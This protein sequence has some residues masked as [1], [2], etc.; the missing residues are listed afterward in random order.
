MLPILSVLIPKKPQAMRKR[1]KGQSMRGKESIDT[2]V[3]D[4]LAGRI[5]V[6]AFALWWSIAAVNAQQSSTASSSGSVLASSG[7]PAQ[8]SSS[9]GLYRGS[10]IKGLLSS[11]GRIFFDNEQNALM[12]MD[13]PENIE[14]ID[15]Y[16]KTVDVPSK[17]VL[18]E[19]RVVEVTLEG[20]HAF[21]VNWTLFAKKQGW[22]LGQF[23]LFS[24]LAGNGIKQSIPYKTTYYPPNQTTIGAEDPFSLTIF[25]EN[26]NVVLKALSN[27]LHTTVLSAPSITTVNN[28]EAT[29]K[30]AQKLPWA[31][32]TFNTSTG[33]TTTTSTTWIAHF[34]DVGIILSVKPTVS[35]DGNIS[36]I[37]MPVVSDKT[38][39][40]NLTVTSPSGDKV[41]YSIPVIDTRTAN[42][43]VIV[44][45]GQTLIMG[46]LIKNSATKGETKVPFLGNIPGLG[47]LFKSKKETRL[48]T[49]LLI[50][51]SP[52]IITPEEMKRA[53]TIAKNVDKETKGPKVILNKSSIVDELTKTA[54]A[55]KKTS[56]KTVTLP[57]NEAVPAAGVLAQPTKGVEENVPSRAALEE[58]RSD[59][60]EG[61]L[62]LTVPEAYQEEKQRS[63]KRLL[64]LF[65]K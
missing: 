2:P 64:D 13:Y 34:E 45:D 4:A 30:V 11:A 61:P 21:G 16:L 60:K 56:L 32:P 62:A 65:D 36:M 52:K 38:S 47:Y 19:A 10:P 29:I 40:F 28:R 41:S 3:R 58:T 50:F 5:T 31:E 22:Q 25:D 24:D 7:N 6:V 20:E 44:G 46:G 54:A 37:L 27:R 12:V 8:A 43:K 53:K 42:T 1:S 55:Q 59:A 48:K 17:Q 35:D 9:A 57:K 26:I 14:R 51:I 33:T 39:D 18:I 49:E 23:N 15:E 63:V